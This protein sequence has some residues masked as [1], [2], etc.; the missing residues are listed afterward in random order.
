MDNL[1]RLRE[2]AGM[3]KEADEEILHPDMDFNDA[4]EEDP[5]QA[6]RDAIYDREKK[7]THLIAMAFDRVGI[8]V[9]NEKHAILYT[10]DELREARVELDDF[11]ITLTQLEKLKSS[12]I[13]DDDFVIQATNDI[14][15]AIKFKVSISLD[16]AIGINHF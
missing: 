12:G 16:D 13:C 2:L 1:K 11:E 5:E 7:I 3:I 4:D 14:G 6:Q 8:P 10:E 9:V 15:L